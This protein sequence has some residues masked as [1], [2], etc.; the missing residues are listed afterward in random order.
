MT[1]DEIV[2]ATQIE[3]GFHDCSC[4]FVVTSVS[5][6]VCGLEEQAQT[7]ERRA[8]EIRH[9]E[10]PGNELCET[11]NSLWLG[12]LPSKLCGYLVSNVVLQET[13]ISAAFWTDYRWGCN[14]VSP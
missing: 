4:V 5:A 10:S 2:N 14:F 12:I 3:F 8:H 1:G 6:R 7:M 13:C 11:T 9:G